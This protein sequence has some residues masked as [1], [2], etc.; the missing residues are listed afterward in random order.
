MRQQGPFYRKSTRPRFSDFQPRLQFFVKVNEWRHIALFVASRYIRKL[1]SIDYV[2]ICFSESIVFAKIYLF[3]ILF[4][5]ILPG[6][7]VW[8]Y[9][10]FLISLFINI[11]TSKTRPSVSNARFCVLK[12]ILG[13][14]FRSTNTWR[15]LEYIAC[16][17]HSSYI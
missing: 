12:Q 6:G 16:L 10:S 15:I 8:G 2:N 7:K 13:Q 5:K 14:V 4:Q 3:S 9:P 17:V 1:S 11:K